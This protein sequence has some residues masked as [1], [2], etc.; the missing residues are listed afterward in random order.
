MGQT[1][2]QL[3][4]LIKLLGSE[5]FF[6]I[7]KVETKISLHIPITID[8]FYKPFFIPVEQISTFHTSELLFK[9]KQLQIPNDAS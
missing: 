1:L 3:P 4:G 7:F 2:P 6:G 5:A 9:Q 8:I